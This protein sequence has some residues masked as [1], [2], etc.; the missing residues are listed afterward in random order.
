MDDFGLKMSDL[1][2]K[3]ESISPVV[4]HNHIENNINNAQMHNI[5]KKE[6]IFKFSFKE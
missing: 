4:W 6:Q 5:L 1:K 3:F 2:P